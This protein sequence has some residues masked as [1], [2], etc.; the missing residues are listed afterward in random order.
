MAFL[1]PGT[2][3]L[4]SSARPQLSRRSLLVWGAGLTVMAPAASALAGC[5][6]RDREPNEQLMTM[7][8]D[9]VAL[10]QAAKQA[11][12]GGLDAA[13]ATQLQHVDEEIV[14]L[15]GHTKSGDIPASCQSLDS[16]PTESTQPSPDNAGDV[17]A[18]LRDYAAS[19]LGAFEP[20]TVDNGL[21]V[22]LFAG[23]QQWGAQ[24]DLI[25]TDEVRQQR[26]QTYDAAVQ[27]GAQ[28]GDASAVTDVLNRLYAA[29][30]GFG[31]AIGHVSGA[32]RENV[33]SAADKLRTAREAIIGS[34]QTANAEVAFPQGGYQFPTR[35]T[36]EASSLQ[37]VIEL[38]EAIST[39]CYQSAQRVAADPI[40]SLLAHISATS[41]IDGAYFKARIGAPTISAIPGLGL[42][43]IAK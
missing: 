5:S 27:A 24:Y 18:R 4:S 25:P 40:F 30:Y 34:L 17:S 35:P 22:G 36:D 43:Y 6:P 21:L 9:L 7:R 15:C 37:L 13:S 12:L 39:Q 32:Y 33:M 29:I 20:D 28:K 26:R 8:G 10:Q 41:A 16:V 1:L 19:V 2:T 11:G 14:R 23:T 3:P 38:S 42:D 31:L